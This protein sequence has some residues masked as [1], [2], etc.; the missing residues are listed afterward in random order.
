[1]PRPNADNDPQ[2]L[3]G[4]SLALA[5]TQLASQIA[6]GFYRTFAG[7]PSRVGREQMLEDLDTAFANNARRV[8]AKRRALRTA[9]IVLAAGLSA[10]AFLIVLA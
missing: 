2:D 5:R 1:M 8:V 9:L 10:A 3:L 7:R 6:D 4:D